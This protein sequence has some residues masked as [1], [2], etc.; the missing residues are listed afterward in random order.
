[1]RLLMAFV[2]D[3]SIAVAWFAVSQQTPYSQI[4]LAQTP[5]SDVHVPAIWPIE[6]ASVPLKELNKGE[7]TSTDVDRFL[8]LIDS[9]DIR[10]ASNEASIPALFESARGYGLRPPD[11]TYVDLA[12]RLGLPL[13][14][15]DDKMREAALRAGVE[16]LA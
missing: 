3:A 1:M 4:V 14:A 8:A 12:L 9:F 10:V 13:A 6:T 11:A 2:L 7:I 5:G 16:L 15:A